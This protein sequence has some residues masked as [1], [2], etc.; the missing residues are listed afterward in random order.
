MDYPSDVNDKEWRLIKHYFK[1]GK[2]GNRS[3]YEKRDLVNAV[4]YVVKSG[5][6][7]R[8]LPHD[9]PPWKTVYSFY[10][11]A[12]NRGIWEKIMSDLVKNSRVKMGRSSN[13]SYSIIDSQSVK[14]ADA[15]EA[16]GIDGG[17]K[18]QRS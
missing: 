10:K 9:F 13:P 14:T 15:A 6:Q 2:Y 16:R 1:Y 12:Q 18:N 5:C 17:K 3:C 11:R 8:M 4:F 7:W